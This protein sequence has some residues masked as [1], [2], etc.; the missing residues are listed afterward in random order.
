MTWP[1]C[2]RNASRFHSQAQQELEL[3]RA[4]H[5]A[6]AEELIDTLADVLRGMER[7]PPMPK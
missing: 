7:N 1:K 6:L 3:I 5:R 4:R 2:S